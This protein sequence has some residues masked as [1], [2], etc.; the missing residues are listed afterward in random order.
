MMKRELTFLS[1]DC[2]SLKQKHTCLHG[3][4]GYIQEIVISGE[5]M[6][7]HK[8]ANEIICIRKI[9]FEDQ[10]LKLHFI[11]SILF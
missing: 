1:N 3:E 10:F 4:L 11:L 9:Q 7:I 2:K 6:N 8:D 5:I